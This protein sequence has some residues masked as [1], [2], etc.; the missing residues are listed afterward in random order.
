MFNSDNKRKTVSNNL[1]YT[2]FQMRPLRF[3]QRHCPRGAFTAQSK[4]MLQKLMTYSY[5]A[6]SHNWDFSAFR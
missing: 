4:P 6:S 3:L 1:E 5:T 2:I